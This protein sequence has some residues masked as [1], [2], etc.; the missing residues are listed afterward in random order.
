[1]VEI[2]IQSIKKMSLF[3]VQKEFYVETFLSDVSS[4]KAFKGR[5]I[6]EMVVNDSL[7]DSSLGLVQK[8]NE[9]YFFLLAYK[10]ETLNKDTNT[11]EIVVKYDNLDADLGKKLNRILYQYLS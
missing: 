9:L 3:Q 2:E 6:V 5:N 10:G 4:S 7:V 11:L 1:M 8:G